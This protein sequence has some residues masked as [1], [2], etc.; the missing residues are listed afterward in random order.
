MAGKPKKPLAKRS[1]APRAPSRR[2]RLA[3]RPTE[4]KVEIDVALKK[5]W[6]ELLKTVMEAKREGASAFDQLWEAAAAI[7]EHDPPLYLAGGVAT[8]KAFFVQHLGENERTARRNM[9]VAKYASPAEEARFGTSKLD[10]ALAY[11]EAKSGGALQGRLPV[12]FD[13]LRIPAERDGK[14]KSVLL[15]DATVQEIA[16]ATRKLSRQAHAPHPKAS[17][18]VAAVTK[19]FDTGALRG[20][21]VRLAGGKVSIGSVPVEALTELGRAL[22]RFK[23]PSSE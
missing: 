12:D 18:V 9:R 1:P 16:A 8:A 3:T 7:V 6:D 15:A 13:K 23:S 10:A 11:L 17:P 2:S 21:S 20:V 22:S 19:L 4:V 5:R 14:P